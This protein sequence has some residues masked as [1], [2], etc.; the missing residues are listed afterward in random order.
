MLSFINH[1][2]YNAVCQIWKYW[3]ITRVKG[4]FAKS[5]SKLSKNWCM[6]CTV[7]L[8]R[9]FKSSIPRGRWWGYYLP[10]LSSLLQLCSWRRYSVVPI[11]ILSLLA[12]S[13]KSA[14]INPV[15]SPIILAHLQCRPPLSLYFN[16]YL[17]FCARVVS[18]TWN[19]HISTDI[20]CNG[21]QQTNSVK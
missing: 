12:S 11:R 13:K 18:F 2:D 4:I 15:S 3:T 6:S 20:L 16:P 17:P 8:K 10:T 9:K 19:S 1:N 5:I 14:A 21:L 7:K